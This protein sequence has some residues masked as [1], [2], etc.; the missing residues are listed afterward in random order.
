MAGDKGIEDPGVGGPVRHVPV[1]LSDV[2]GALAPATGDIIVD[3]TFGAGGYSA[4]ILNA[5]AD[6]LAI[7]R[8]PTAVAAGQ[9]LVEASSGRLALVEGQFS[10]LE[11]I[12]RQRYSAGVDG[13]VLDIGVSSMQIDQAERGFSFQKDGP[14]DMR[15]GASGPTAAD[16]V[17]L[18]KPADLT[19]VLGL[20]GEERQ[21]GRISRAI[22]A[23][24]DEQPFERTLDLARL[25]GNVVGRSPKD[26]IDP[27][28]RSFQG[29][30]IFVNDELG[31]LARALIAAERVL[32]PGG[33]LVVVTFHSLEDRIVK[34]FLRDRSSPPA[35]SRHLPNAV[36]PPQTFTA[37]NKAVAASDEEAVRN[38]RSRSAK[39][40][41]GIRTDAAPR[42]EADG[43]AFANLPNLADLPRT[44][45]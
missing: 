42:Q 18:L 22:A 31:E 19:R 38:P 1:L 37:S 24:R 7:D 36:V 16:V 30:R 21:A 15:M 27:A 20:L 5:G 35:G 33:R 8:D 25:I 13:I 2:V 29:L 41:A 4:A 11:R 28:T 32:K 40:R 3:G 34:R 9:G 39:L 44:G 17:N 43:L 12:V 10:D 23:R 14:L 6:V 45:A 26:K